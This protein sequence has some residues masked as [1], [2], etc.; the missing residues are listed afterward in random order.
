MKLIEVVSELSTI[1]DWKTICVAPPWCEESEC[2]L[3]DL[4]ERHQVPNDVL[5]SGFKY[6]L[7]VHVALEVLEVFGAKKISVGDKV[8]LLVFYA[9]NDAYPDWVYE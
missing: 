1:D 7:E 4:D 6:F 8:R 2:K 5:I 9:E 3:I